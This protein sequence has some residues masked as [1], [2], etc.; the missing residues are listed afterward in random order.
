MAGALTP[1]IQLDEEVDDHIEV[2]MET[3]ARG[4]T[5]RTQNDEGRERTERKPAIDLEATGIVSSHR[6]QL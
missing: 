2:E 5:A 6:Y 1:T 3:T 4:E